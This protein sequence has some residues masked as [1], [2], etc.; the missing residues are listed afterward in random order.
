MINS[1]KDLK[2]SNHKYDI[3][4]LLVEE[5]LS[6]NYLYKDTEKLISE[7][8]KYFHTSLFICNTNDIT[9]L[10]NILISILSKKE[11]TKLINEFFEKDVRLF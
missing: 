7:Y 9:N 5:L 2:N 11:A 10:E 1:V 8:N 3:M 6:L 4:K